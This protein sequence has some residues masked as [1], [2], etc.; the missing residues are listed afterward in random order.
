MKGHNVC[1]D[2][3]VVLVPFMFEL[4][5]DELWRFP[6]FRKELN[7][8]GE[9][10]YCGRHGVF[11]RMSQFICR[12]MSVI[13]GQVL[14]EVHW[15]EYGHVF[16]AHQE[17]VFS[18]CFRFCG[19]CAVASKPGKEGLL[20]FVS[21]AMEIHLIHLF[22]GSLPW[23]WRKKEEGHFVRPAELYA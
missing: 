21:W 12:P 5:F 14:I 13:H 16:D 18:I 20:L 22:G 6:R 8:S 15:I 4:L 23:K 2:G 7:G 1:H 19:R 11:F 10:F 3:A 9:E 17:L